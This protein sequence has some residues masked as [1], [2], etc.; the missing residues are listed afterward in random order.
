MASP[1]RYPLFGKEG[2]G[3]ILE[4]TEIIYLKIPLHPPLSKGE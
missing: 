2:I 4:L 1:N 3:E